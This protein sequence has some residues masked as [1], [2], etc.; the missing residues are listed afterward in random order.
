MNVCCSP[1]LNLSTLAALFCAG[2][3]GAVAD[4][5]LDCTSRHPRCGRRAEKSNMFLNFSAD[6]L[7]W[8]GLQ[9]GSWYS[10]SI[11]QMF[12]SII[13]PRGLCWRR[14]RTSRYPR[15]QSPAKAKVH[16]HAISGAVLLSMTE[17]DH[18]KRVLGCVGS[19]GA[20]GSVPSG[21]LARR[22][23]KASASRSSVTAG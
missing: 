4:E 22:I 5:A 18:S 9:Q 13:G 11:D 2:R 1:A 20:V 6:P 19:F 14:I 16:L 10:C 12:A 3:C 23:W 15:A 17:E 21:R 8:S 7:F